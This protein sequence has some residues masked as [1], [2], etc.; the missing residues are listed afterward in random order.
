MCIRNCG[1]FAAL[2]VLLVLAAV[3]WQA[4]SAGALQSTTMINAGVYNAC[5]NELVGLTGEIHTVTHITYD[6]GRAHVVVRVNAQGVEG[7]SSEGRRYRATRNLG[8]TA[9]GDGLPFSSTTVQSFNLVSAG[10]GP[11]ML[12]H[13]TAHITVNANGETTVEVQNVSGDECGM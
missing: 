3:P 4:N 1:R 10:S 12:V 7:F 11:N 6:S 5:A 8:T 9:N 13:V 2:T